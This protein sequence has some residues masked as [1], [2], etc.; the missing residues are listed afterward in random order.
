MA[1]YA[2]Y[3][4]PNP[5]WERAAKALSQPSASDA[6]VEMLWARGNE[7]VYEPRIPIGFGTGDISMK[8][9]MLRSLSTNLHIVTVNV[10]YRLEPFPRPQDDSFTAL[11]WA[12]TNSA[13]I[14]VDLHKGFLVMGESAGGQ[15]AAVMAQRALL[16][17][18]F[19][20]HSLTGQI[21]QFPVLCHPGHHPERH[22]DRLLSMEQNKDAPLLTRKDVQGVFDFLGG[23]PKDPS[24]SPL[25]A[26][27]LG[28]LPRVFIQ[29]AGLDPLRDEAILYRLHFNAKEVLFDRY[30]G[31]PHSF[32]DIV[33][34]THAGMRF[35]QDTENAITWMIQSD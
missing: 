7:A 14:S 29:A 33:S 31:M 18:F 15:I 11:K 8:D 27:R 3:S 10:E 5:D 1:Q 13:N 35:M 28:G 34:E 32:G 26:S 16:D 22:K 9:Y 30:S 4:K 12:V 21:L 25:L 6:P 19:H 17:P 24:V 2:H 23:D 20:D